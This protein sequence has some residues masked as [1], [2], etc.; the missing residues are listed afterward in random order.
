MRLGAGPDRVVL[1]L[2]L[3]AATSVGVVA[4][5]AMVGATV[6]IR[7]R[8]QAAAPR[9]RRRSR[10][11]AGRAGH[12]G[13]GV[14]CRSPPRRRIRRRRRR[15]RRCRRRG[16]ADN[17][18]AGPPGRRRRRGHAQRGVPLVV[19]RAVGAA[20]GVLAARADPWPGHRDADGDRAAGSG[21]AA[22]ILFPRRCRYGWSAHHRGG[23]GGP[24]RH[25]H[26]TRPA[27]RCRSVALSA[28]GG[29]RWMAVGHRG[30][31]G[32]C[33]AAVV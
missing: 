18:G 20:R 30:A 9:P 25:R 31:A 29:I 12:P 23:A 15:D 16:A 11:A 21:R 2:V 1:G 32:L 22:T 13:R 10:C 26:R 28:L 4:A 7:R 6:E 19:A 17:R 8:S 5:A 27:D 3:A 24:S 33:R 14:A